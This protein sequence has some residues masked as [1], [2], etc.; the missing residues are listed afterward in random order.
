MLGSG[1]R[2]R[3]FQSHQKDEVVPVGDGCSSVEPKGG[4]VGS[5]SL[6]V[7]GLSL[8]VAAGVAV[9]DLGFGFFWRTLSLFWEA[10]TSK[11]EGGDGTSELKP[12]VVPGEG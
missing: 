7:V 4:P 3:R 12:A 8:V 9:V 6:E 10:R 1:N 11:G 2:T 5:V